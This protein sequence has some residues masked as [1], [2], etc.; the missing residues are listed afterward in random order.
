VVDEGRV[1]RLLRGVAD[2][3]RRLGEAAQRTGAARDDLW[4]DGVKYLFV[5]TIEGCVDVAQHITSSERFR[6]PDSNADALRLLGERGVIDPLLATSLAR[7]VGFRNVLVHQYAAV[8]DHL[9][10]E[11]LD[12][13]DEFERFVAEVSAWMLATRD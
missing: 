11:A 9:V 5:T 1:T 6:A 12:R 3:T 2:R 4:L 7:A 8:D 10:V 13:L